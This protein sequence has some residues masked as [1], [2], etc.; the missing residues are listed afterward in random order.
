MSSEE[1]TPSGSQ[2]RPKS[3]VNDDCDLCGDNVGIYELKDFLNRIKKGKLAN[4]VNEIHF[5][6]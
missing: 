4:R 6:R 2:K 5:L 1:A 3:E